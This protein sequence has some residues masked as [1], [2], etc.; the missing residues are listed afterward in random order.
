MLVPAPAVLLLLLSTRF[1]SAVDSS[2]ILFDDTQ[3]YGRTFEGIGGLSAGASTKLLA[4][5]PK[6]LQEEILDF[7]FLP[8]FGAS[9]QIL[10]VEIGGD[11]Q[12]TDGTEA[13]HMHSSWDENYSRGYEWWLMV[14]AKKRNPDIK[15]YALPWGFPGWV[16]QGTSSPYTN[17]SVLADYI[18]RWIAGAKTNYNLDIDFIGVWNERPYNKD[19]IKTLRKVLDQRGFLNVLIIAS[20]DG[21]EIADDVLND[22][23]LA[24]DVYAIGCHYPGTTSSLSAKLTGNILW[25]SEDYSTFNDEVG[26]GCWARIL[27]QNYVNGLMTSTISWCLIASYYQGL[28]FYRDGL[29]TAVEPWSGNYVVNSPIWVSAHTTQFTSIGWKYLQHGNGVGKLPQGGSYV[30]LASPSGSDLTIVL[31]TMTHDHSLCIRPGLPPYTVSPQNVTIVLRG[32]FASIPQLY[33]WYSQ[34]GFN[35]NLSN[36]FVNK[37]VVKV[38]NGAVQLSLGLDEL[39]TLTTVST[40]LKGSYPSPPASRPFPLPYSDDFE[41]NSLHEEP[42]NLAQQTG[43]FEVLSSGTNQ[44]IRQMV[45]SQPIGWCDAEGL[46]KAINIIGNSTWQDVLIEVDFEFPAVNASTGVFVAARLN[47]TGCDLKS[48]FGI[49]LFVTSNYSFVLANDPAMSIVIIRGPL[50]AGGGWHRLSLFVQGAHAYGAYD[51]QLIFFVQIPSSPSF[52]FAGLGTNSFGFA[53]FDN[54]YI[55]ANE[56]GITKMKHYINHPLPH[57]LYFNPE[58]K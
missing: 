9:L 55:A 46:G 44:F 5:Y 1:A 48:N 15:L 36:M 17:S 8:N 21:W 43:A 28:P 34:L 41:G 57:P 30:G 50:P 53:D 37:G 27:N 39:F 26:A 12:S 24:I 33:V 40:G 45:L 31:E 2:S 4:N 49:Y 6:Q 16:G 54:L 32:R 35:G 7:L 18:V 58:H 47:R 29:M 10:K 56:E 22:A 42:N 11:V 19:Y 52:G 14:E 25:S 23:E 3:G 13:S 20:D 38:V 51:E